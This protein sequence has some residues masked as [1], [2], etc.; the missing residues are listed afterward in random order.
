MTDRKRDPLPVG[1]Q[2]GDARPACTMCLLRGDCDCTCATCARARDRGNVDLEG[3]TFVDRDGN[4]YV[5]GKLYVGHA[6]DIN[7]GRIETP[8][9]WNVIEGEYHE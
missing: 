1:Y 7:S 5:V 6:P 8:H 4:A 2:F 3:A 9:G